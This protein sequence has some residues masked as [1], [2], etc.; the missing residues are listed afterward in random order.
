MDPSP[1]ELDRAAALATPTGF[2]R[3]VGL[4]ALLDVL[5]LPAEPV[6]CGRFTLLEKLGEGAMGEV[7][8]ARDPQL[9][10]D[11]A[12]KLLHEDH[13][14][15]ANRDQ[16]GDGPDTGTAG[17][18]GAGLRAE[19]RALARLTHPN[20]VGV[21]G[22]G[23]D[24]GR[25]WI[26]M[27]LV[28][29]T[30]LGRWA[31]LHAAETTGHVRALALL[32]GAGAGLAA[33]HA[34]GLVHRDFKP[35]NVLIG[36][37]GRVEVADFGLAQ[38]GD[39]HATSLADLAGLVLD[40]TTRD[41]GVRGSAMVGTPRYM[42]PEQVLRGSVD[43]RSDQFAFAISAWEILTGDVPFAGGTMADRLDQIMSGTFEVR[44]AARLPSRLRRVLK[45][46][47]AADPAQ[48]F[49]SMNDL[50]DAWDRALA[51]RGAI[52]WWF[53]A[54]LAGALVLGAMRGRQCSGEG[55]REGFARIWNDERR[56]E[57]AAALQATG[58]PWADAALAGI[59]DALDQRAD[60]WIDADVAACEASAAADDD[61]AALDQF[62]QF[63]LCRNGALDLTDAWLTRLM[64]AD[65]RAAERAV[66]G[67][68]SL[69]MPHECEP[70]GTSVKPEDPRLRRELADARVAYL[71]GDYVESGRRAQDLADEAA[72]LDR[73]RIRAEA[74]I[75]AARA[76]SEASSAD[77][78]LV[79]GEAHALAI[80]EDAPALAFDA[81]ALATTVRANQGDHEQARGWL[82]HAEV[83]A[84]RLPHDAGREVGLMRARCLVLEAQGEL[85]AAVQGCTAALAKLEAV[86][87]PDPSR[88]NALRV[89]IASLHYALGHYEVALALNTTMLD[90]SER[91]FGAAH[92]RTGGMNLNVGQAAQALGDF[93][94]AEA[95][96]LRAAEIFRAAYGDNH[97]WVVS[98]LM[99]LGSMRQT[100]DDSIGAQAAAEAALDACGGR[101][102]AATARVLHNLAE[103][104][105]MQGA[106]AEALGLLER[107]VAI[108]ADALPA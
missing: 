2:A 64:G 103:A 77:V 41:R 60:T 28:Q 92:P 48:R 75:A 30:S 42:A 9:Q 89:E 19:A 15:A 85:A 108:E 61:G 57:L 22:L 71:S 16:G 81:A 100:Q 72:A 49:S 50:L 80:A 36:D 95:S 43:A 63:A 59:G 62:A 18:A 35:A 70:A 105:R 25:T 65:R 23:R 74:L 86:P 55:A 88:R 1:D 104:R 31:E 13:P 45:R 7:Y 82:R 46:A 26:A 40:A 32:R 38:H 69:P 44:S 39:A 106:A 101:R 27:E 51:P 21:L 76:L 33:A 68:R 58:V 97:R 14:N 90:E 56:S 102:D 24:R 12:I 11:V 99:N 98:A 20:V 3:G 93:G 73:P 29:G 53:V 47:L 107:V 10:R 17:R 84:A 52:G 83:A 91:E 78:E 54:A 67:A 87:R 34:V 5:G 96:Y 4:H 6:R 79:L 66:T 8:R 37:D 94:L